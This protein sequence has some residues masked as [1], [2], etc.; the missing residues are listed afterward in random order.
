MHLPI[1]TKE[2]NEKNKIKTKT[3]KNPIFSKK[4]GWHYDFKKNIKFN[5][6]IETIIN[7]FKRCDYFSSS[8]IFST[9]AL[10]KRLS[11]LF[12]FFTI[13]GDFLIPISDICHDD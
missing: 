11:I 5:K 10:S 7:E 3:K 13:K 2:N 6:K 12:L 8:Y 4:S 1:G 9:L